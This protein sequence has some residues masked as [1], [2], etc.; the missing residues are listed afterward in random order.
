MTKEEIGFKHGIPENPN[1]MWE[2]QINGRTFS[3]KK[4]LQRKGLFIY[5]CQCREEHGSISSASSTGF[6][7]ERDLMPD[8][9]ERLPQFADFISS[10][11][12]ER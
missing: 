8:E 1:K 2:T 4:I 10:H 11:S 7:S 9:I 3:F 5:N 12:V 6:Y